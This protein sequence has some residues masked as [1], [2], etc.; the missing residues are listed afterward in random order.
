MVMEMNVFL[1]SYKDETMSL[2]WDVNEHPKQEN[3]RMH[4]H[5]GAE[6]FFF[7]GGKGVFHVEGAEYTLERGDLLLFQPSEAHYIELDESTRYER[8]TF[9]IYPELFKEIDPTGELLRPILDRKPGKWNLYRHNQFQDGGCM[10]YLQI[11]LSETG[12]PHTNAVAGLVGLLHEVYRI[13]MS[14]EPETEETDSVEYRIIRD[15]N[16]NLTQSIT[17]DEICARYYISKPQLCRR[18]KKATG[19][20]LYHYITV[21]RLVEARK[22]L[23]AGGSPVQVG[24]DVGFG[25]YS[26][27]YRAYRKQFG[28]S[29]SEIEIRR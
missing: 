4:T 29:P 8:A 3:Y 2:G 19:T 27:F 28:C 5:S 14:R 11:I 17:L 12:D 15:I 18:F 20:S 6:A 21:K 7:L 1:F 23:R 16:N 9:H 25:D 13:F 24:A 22:R 10:R 26:S